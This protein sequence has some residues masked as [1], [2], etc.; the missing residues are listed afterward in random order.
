MGRIQD[1]S[2]IK[3]KNLRSNFTGWEGGGAGGG[4]DDDDY[5]ITEGEMPSRTD[6]R[7]W[8]GPFLSME[9]NRFCF[10]Y[11]HSLLFSTFFKNENA[12]VVFI[13]NIFLERP[14]PL[15]GS[16]YSFSNAYTAQKFIG[17]IYK[18]NLSSVPR[19]S[20]WMWLTKKWLCVWRKY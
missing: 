18:G 16:A 11:L 20:I 4:E 15:P 9:S 5:P 19:A 3:N 1:L 12:D 7:C 13:W 10:F 17:S 14:I 8:Q 6:T 2:V